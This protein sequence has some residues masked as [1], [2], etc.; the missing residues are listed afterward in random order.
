MDMT[1]KER[2]TWLSQIARIH[3]DQKALRDKETWEQ[4]ERLLALRTEGEA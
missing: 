3:R 4:T 2:T 1:G